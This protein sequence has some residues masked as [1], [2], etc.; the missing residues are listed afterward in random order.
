VV[1]GESGDTNRF[2]QTRKA[3]GGFSVRGSSFFDSPCFLNGCYRGLAIRSHGG[4]NMEF[5]LYTRGFWQSVEKQGGAT[6]NDTRSANAPFSRRKNTVG[7]R[8]ETHADQ[9]QDHAAPNTGLI[10]ISLFLAVLLEVIPLE[11]DAVHAMVTRGHIA[12]AIV[13]KMLCLTLIFWPLFVYVYRNGFG[14]LKIVWGRVTIICLI[15]LVHLTG[16]VFLLYTV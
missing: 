5:L 6:Y 16:S 3:T 10:K 13:F 9:E 2:W 7:P 11:A 14:A 8:N 12:H 4:H 1:Q 15:A